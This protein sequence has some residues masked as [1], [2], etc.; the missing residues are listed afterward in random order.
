MTS[1]ETGEGGRS[2]LQKILHPKT[3]KG[4][5]TRDVTLAVLFFLI[6]GTAAYAFSGVWPPVVNVV[7]GSMEPNIDTGDMLLVV[8]PE[9]LDSN[10]DG[11]PELQTY[12]EA[13][14]DGEQNFGSYGDVIVYQSVGTSQPYPILHRV[15]FHVE[16]G[17]N[18]YSK[19]DK[20]F[21]RARNCSELANCPAPRTGYITKGDDNPTYDQVMGISEP[22]PSE[23]IFAVAEYRIPDIGWLRLAIEDSSTPDGS[24][25]SNRS[26]NPTPVPVPSN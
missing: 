14:A 13:K 4:V 17:E 7:S 15:R 5:I 24:T 25:P 20:S 6:L 9:K 16:K 21:I 23:A 10:E 8:N 11:V 2:R 26:T 3:S 22:V 1:D 19:A 12:R 18:W